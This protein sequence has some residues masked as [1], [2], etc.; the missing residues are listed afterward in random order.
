MTIAI[1]GLGL[2]GGSAAKAYQGAGHTVYGLDKDEAVLGFAQLAGVVAAP[3]NRENLRECACLLIAL[4]PAAAVRFLQDWAPDIPQQCLVMDLCGTKRMVCERGFALAAQYG[5][6]F[7]G[8]HPMAGS[9][10]SGYAHSRADLFAGA[11]MI[12]VPPVTDDMAFLE[13]IKTLLEPLKLRCIT[14]ATAEEHD[15]N[16]AF[17]SQLAHVVS[18][19]YIKSPT[20][21][22][23]KGFSAGSYRDLTRV[24]WLAP[25]MWTELFLENRDHLIGEI[26]GLIAALT[27][28]RDAIQRGDGDELCRLL[29][30]GK[31]RKEEVDG[32]MP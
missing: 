16:I 15:K 27:E 2:I 30:D 13:Q 14:V 6:T 29:E 8:G 7:V 24:A 12:V 3:L 23:H 11:S 32:C 26:D 10:H 25:D 4:P 20:A 18:N 17:T 9:H 28:Y 31:R 1:V 5:F 21:G 19:A 22:R